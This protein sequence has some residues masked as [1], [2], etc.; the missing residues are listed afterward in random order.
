MKY[1]FWSLLL[2]F[3]IKGCLLGQATFNKTVD[4]SNGDE[5]GWS[6]VQVDDGYILIGGGWGFEIGDYFDEKIKFAKTDLD[7]NVVWENFIGEPSMHYFCGPQSGILTQDG[8]IVFCGS[9]LSA[10]TYSA[11]L[12]KFNPITGDTIFLK[13]FNFDDALKGL[14]VHELSDGNLIILATDENDAYGSILIKTTEGGEFIWQKRYGVAYENAATSFG[15]YSDTICLINRNLFCT[16][17]GYK[18]RTIDMEGALIQ[19]LMFDVSCP[20]MGFLSNQGG[21]YGVGV[22]F[23]I[24]PYQSFIYRTDLDGLMQWNYNTSFD[25]DTLEYQDLFPELVRELPNGD[26]V[27]GGY[28]ASNY[29]GTYF[30]MISKINT[31]GEPYWERIYTSSIDV[32]ND[33]RLLDL[34]IGSDNEIVLLGSGFNENEIEDQNFWLLKLDSLGCLVPGCD[35][36]GIQI[37]DLT[38]GNDKISA[39]PNPFSDYFNIV[40]NFNEGGLFNVELFNI[41]NQMVYNRENVYINKGRVETRLILVDLLPGIYILTLTSPEQIVSIKVFK[42]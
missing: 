39:Y 11:I 8:N 34:E 1:I 17:E 23:P 38:I 25:M 2:L 42:E 27:V 41:S 26:L 5:V 12:I 19:E 14:Q 18:I 28:F 29:L 33:S 22:K 10:I 13:E 16:P 7:G 20:S 24:P 32:Y 31:Y 21:F 6:L 35:T 30:G 3:S 36:M 15:I 37:F 40:T 4:F 9:K